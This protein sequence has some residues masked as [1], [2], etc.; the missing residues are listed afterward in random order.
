[1]NPHMQQARE[2]LTPHPVSFWRW[3]H[4]G[5]AAQ[6]SDGVTIALRPELQIIFPRLAQEGLP[7]L[8]LLLLVLAAC[9]DSWGTDRVRCLLGESRNHPTRRSLSEM[10]WRDAIDSL[11][12]IN[13]LPADLR[14]SRRRHIW[15]QPATAS[16]NSTIRLKHCSYWTTAGETLPSRVTV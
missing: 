14:T 13:R 2:W 5:E 15:K 1:M 10:H 6:W 3:S 12:R 8:D 7:P 11:T 4:D 16:R 9:R